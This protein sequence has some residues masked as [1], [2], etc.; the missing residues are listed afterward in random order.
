[1]AT[2]NI[3]TLA[4]VHNH[5]INGIEQPTAD[6]RELHAFLQ[7]GRDFS[8]WIKGRID[9]YGFLENQDFVLIHQNGGIKKGRGG[10]R[11][12]IDYALT[13]DMGKELAMLEQND[14]GREAR[15][16]FIECEKQLKLTWQQSAKAAT[17]A[18]EDRTEHHYWLVVN[19][20]GKVLEQVPLPDENAIRGQL[21]KYYPEQ[22]MADRERVMKTVDDVVLLMRETAERAFQMTTPLVSVLGTK[23][24]AGQA[25]ADAFWRKRR[26][27]AGAELAAMM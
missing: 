8:T 18:L 10:D 20:S 19:D 24:G 15:R 1:M 6:A 17:P 25:E 21:G 14:K 9:E 7:V 16:Y 22:I 3:T 12:S 26:I 23:H 5:V 2:K 11:R 4:T 27:Q 13:F